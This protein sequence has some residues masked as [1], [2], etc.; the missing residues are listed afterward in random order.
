MKYPLLVRGLLLGA[1]LTGATGC[2]GTT[3]GSQ[4]LRSVD[5][6][7]TGVQSVHVECEMVRQEVRATVDRMLRLFQPTT[8]EDRL[9]AYAEFEKALDVCEAQMGRFQQSIAKLETLGPAFFDSWQLELDSYQTAN[10]REQSAARLA[11]TQERYRAIL[12][13]SAD[14]ILMY[15]GFVTDV[16]DA[17]LFLGRDLHPEAVRM[18]EGDL[19]AILQ[20]A[21][22]LDSAQE[23]CQQAARTYL[24]HTGL[25][26]MGQVQIE[27]L[28]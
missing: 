6:L 21:R 24:D 26:D 13:S 11:L 17:L 1:L 7:L 14:P 28:P 4:S 25:P 3:R 2:L 22:T 12:D 18:I 20:E 5:N 15:A 9:A 16:R 8:T 10:M 27:P 23:V 19:R